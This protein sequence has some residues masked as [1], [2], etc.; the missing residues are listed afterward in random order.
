[1]LCTVCNDDIYDNEDIKCAKCKTFSH[2]AC[3]GFRESN[4]RKLSVINK[5]KWCCSNC[6]DNPNMSISDT[7]IGKEIILKKDSSKILLDLKNSVDFM[8]KQFD[9]FSTQ[10]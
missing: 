4:F 9:D 5:G 3:A 1:M 10:L 8:S 2:F 7:N 6:K